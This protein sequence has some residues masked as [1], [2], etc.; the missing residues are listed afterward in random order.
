MKIPFRLQ[1]LLSWKESL[2]K[3]SE[4]KIRKI[5]RQLQEIEDAICQ[6][7]LQRDEEEQ[8]LK[9]LL[10]AGIEAGEYL[11][12]R[13]FAEESYR[14]REGQLFKKSL[15]EGELQEEWERFILRRKERKVLELLKE[16]QGQAFL[17][18]IGK[19]SQ[20]QSNEIA[21]R[22]YLKQERDLS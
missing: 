15:I 7:D 20:K 18:Q 1:T 10:A 4:I 17:K 5:K 6:G 3:A 9:R 19:L 12:Q 14:E 13:A 21:L 11:S 16:S 22:A 8:C 2:E